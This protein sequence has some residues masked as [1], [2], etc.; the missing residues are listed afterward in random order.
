M[1][2]KL[3]AAS[4]KA[5]RKPGKYPDGGNLYLQVSEWHTK[6]WLFRYSRFGKD[7]WMGL[8]PY[9][10][11]S[12]SEARDL[13]TA[14]RA[15]IRAGTDPLSD[16]RKRR[17]VGD[18][19]TFAEC[20]EAYIKAHSP[21]WKNPKHK[22][23]WRN[24]LTTF[25]GPVFG[26][27]PVAE[28]NTALILRCLN[29]IWTTKTETA[30][31]LRGRIESV[32]SWATVHG[33][34]EGENPAR[35]RGHLDQLLAAPS[36]VNGV[37]HHPALPYA[38]IGAFMVELHGHKGIAPRALEFCIL[39]ATR[40]AE[41]IAAEWPEID[42]QAKTWTIPAG[43]MKAGREHRVPLSPAAIK[44]LRAVEGHHKKYVF[45]G[46]K[47]GTHLSA[48]GMLAVLRRMNRKDI[49]VHGFRSTFRD[50]CSETTSYPE[51]VAEMALAHTLSDKT[52]AAYRRGDLFEKRRK[53]MNEWARYC[54][55]VRTKA[56]VTPI[57]G[58]RG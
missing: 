45:P 34:R 37:V 20:A 28:V 18:T 19:L 7:T 24:T 42:L 40:T 14:E 51:A 44:A 22:E 30:S 5:K 13:A 53:L 32:L 54:E 38:E 47:R 58:Q 4:V 33:Y 31:R 1:T 49:T 23:Q 11:V 43:R 27:L 6:S 25:A 48:W 50:W 12:L 56:G 9:P 15:K 46:H 29:P 2:A 10:D 17:I 8:G 35:W 16:K 52:E 3:S 21:S 26:P 39:T 41:I 36:R 57:R 55:K